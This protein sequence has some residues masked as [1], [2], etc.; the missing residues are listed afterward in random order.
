VSAP[1][2]ATGSISSERQEP[3]CPRSLVRRQTVGDRS[4]DNRLIVADNVEAL[5]SLRG[6]FDARFRVIYLDPPFNTGRRFEEYADC[7]SPE[8]WRTMMVRRLRLLH[9]LL[10][11][12]GAVFVEIDDTELGSLLQLMDDV[13]GRPQRVSVVTIVRSA[14][15]GHKAIN[16]GPVNVTDF[17]LVYEKSRGRWRYRSERRP[18]AGVDRAYS[19]FLVNPDASES[20]WRFEPLGKVV[21]ASLGFAVRSD[22][23]RALG[24]ARF[25]DEIGRFA[26][27]HA[28][29]VVRF[30][31]PRYE[32]VSREAQALI[33][34]SRA[35]P[36]AIMRLSRHAHPDIVLKGG[37]RLLFLSR[38][39]V[40]SSHGPAMVE[41]LTNLWDDVPFQGLAKEGG[42]VFSRNKKP[43]RLLSRILAMSSDEGDWVLDPFLGSGT[44]AAVAH[45]MGRRWVGIEKGEQAYRLCVP[46]L[47][48]VVA[49]SD[50]T[51]VTRA[52]SW[53]GGG[54]FGVYA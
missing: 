46:R 21:A 39:V 51:G 4:S 1:S 23:V 14:S 45:K 18:R 12:D 47:S 30:A 19:T 16:R 50:P 28:A 34:Q 29:Q 52:T 41:P 8:E 11:D 31:Q 33:D 32:A 48:R 10:A 22:A 2:R 25:Q 6:E 9:P 7:L 17:L 35:Q 5:A 13:F 26:L 36:D 24:K 15:T 49:G 42:V 40:S 44:T 37:N 3:P 53:R 38:K 43:E 54:G 27:S 20:A